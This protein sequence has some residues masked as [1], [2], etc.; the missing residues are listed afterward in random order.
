VN[1]KA[2]TIF[3]GEIHEIF[4]EEREDID[5]SFEEETMGEPIYDEEYVGADICEVFEEEGNIDPIY[6]DEYSSDDIPEFFAK[7]GHDKPIYDDKYLPAKYGESL[8]VKR[9]L[10]TTKRTKEELWVGH[11][12]FHTHCTSQDMDN[13]R[14]ENI[15]SNYIAEKI[16]FQLIEH[17]DPYN[18]QW[19]NKND[20]VTIS[21]HSIVSFSIDNNYKEKLWCDVI[22]MDVCHLFLERPC[23][24]D[25]HAICD[26]YANTYTFVKDVIKIKLAPLLLN[27]FNDG[28]VEFKLLG[29]SLAKEPFKDNTK[30][31][32]FR[33]VPKPPWENVATDL[34]LDYFGLSNRRIL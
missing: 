18:L 8:E 7:G 34:S 17:Q 26:G 23:Q 28:K 1:C 32:L 14:C 29:L 27:E 11:D 16:E 24:Y 12:I 21:Q 22:L 33:P 13:K 20:E 6:D 5:E 2:V 15:A 3:N 31:C 30:L 4:E 10:E 25:H 9:S 19:L